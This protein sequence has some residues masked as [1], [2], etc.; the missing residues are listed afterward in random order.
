MYLEDPVAA[1]R[2]SSSRRTAKCRI[3]SISVQVAEIFVRVN[4]LGAKLRGS[5]LALAQITARWQ[6]ALALLEKFVAECEESWFTID[7]G[8]LVRQIVVFATQRSRFSTVTSIP[9]ER[10]KE[11]WEQSKE[12][13]RF[14]INFLRTNGDIEDESLLSSPYVMIPIAVYGSLKDYRMSPQDECDMLRWLYIA[15]ARGHYSGSSETMLDADLAVLFGG[16]Q[17]GKLM[18]LLKQRFGR[19]QIEPGDLRGRGQR[20]AL[21]SLAYLALK[22]AGAKDWKTGLGL[23]LTHQGN[24]HYIEFHHIFPKS[25]LQKASFEK[26]E[27][28][29]IANMAFV[30]GR[31]NRNISNRKPA[32]YFP[33]IIK[34]RG[35]DALRSQAISLRKIDWE[36]DNYRDFLANRRETLAHA[37]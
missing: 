21:F 14:A 10:L 20:S 27:I 34:E 6:G 3:I 35:E 13:L 19:F 15:N 36:I 29:E 4:S 33:V 37:I 31:V 25:L 28:N 16:A 17:F 9:V 5:D 24:L 7:T 2:S 22:H 12:G 8:L 1:R 18:D 30:S 32:D 23:S 11:A 26:S